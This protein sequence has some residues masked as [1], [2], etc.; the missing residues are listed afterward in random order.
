MPERYTLT[1]QLRRAARSAGDKPAIVHAD[2]AASFGELE[3]MVAIYSLLSQSEG[4]YDFT[5]DLEP[6]ETSLNLS[7]RALFAAET[8]RTRLSFAGSGV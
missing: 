4:S 6:S 8:G 1:G 7:P 3:G 5:R 2:G